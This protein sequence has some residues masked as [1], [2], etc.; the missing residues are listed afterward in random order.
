M[1]CRAGVKLCHFLR[2]LMKL[3]TTWLIALDAVHDR[4]YCSSCEPTYISMTNC[5]QKGDFLNE[6]EC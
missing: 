6:S 4:I 3:L 2:W 5:P 1:F